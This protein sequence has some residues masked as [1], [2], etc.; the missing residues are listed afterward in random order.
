MDIDE[1]MKAFRKIAK[2]LLEIEIINEISPGLLTPRALFA[3]A[4]HAL[5]RGDSL[6]KGEISLLAKEFLSVL[7]EKNV[8]IPD[9]DRDYFSGD[10]T[11]EKKEGKSWIT[12]HVI[13]QSFGH[14]IKQP[15]DAYQ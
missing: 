10:K 15:K 5:K 2:D 12:Q 3:S 1:E 9:R 14:E 7:D 8:E 4:V 13:R 6:N 11:N